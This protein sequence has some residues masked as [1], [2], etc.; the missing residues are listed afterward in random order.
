MLLS[1]LRVMRC[2]SWFW[3][4]I[5]LALLLFGG[6]VL[7]RL[8]GRL[9]LCACGS[10]RF[11][12]GATQSAEN[13]QQLFDPYSFTHLQHGLLFCGLTIWLAP[14]LATA[15]R[16]C[17]A[18]AI[19]ITW[20]VVENSAFVIDRYRTATAA[21][22]YTG[23]TVLNSV[24]DILAC[25]IGFALVSYLGWRRSLLLF[26]AIE[27]CLLVLIRDSLILNVVMLLYPIDAIKVW[28]ASH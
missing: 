8:Q 18:M 1:R 5:L 3:P 9:W 22:G 28:Q 17:I 11:W 2:S 7:L 27:L 21:L 16:F 10:L 15:W 23:D 14:H 13:S 26:V 12:T 20:E 25:A 4:G 24:G 6:V 19:E